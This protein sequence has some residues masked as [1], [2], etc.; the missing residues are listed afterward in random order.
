M[1]PNHTE[2]VKDIVLK[3]LHES[4]LQIE[5]MV[6]GIC[7]EVYGVALP[8]KKVI[9]RMNTDESQLRGVERNIAL[10]SS[11]NIKVPSLITSDYSKKEFP[12]GYQILSYLPGKDLG[13]VIESM[14]DNELKALAV[15]IADIFR[16]L[17]SIPTNGKFGWVGADE[18]RLVDSWAKI[19]RQDKVEE[20]NNQTGVV[21]EKLVNREKELYEKYR[22]YF[23]SVKSIL[24]YDDISSKNVLIN[25]G[26]FSGLVDLDEVTYGD[27]LA[28]IGS[29]KASWYGTHYGEVYTSAVEDVL[30]LTDDQRKMVTVYALFN[31]ILWLSERGIKFNENTNTEVDMDAVK[32]DK[33]L[34]NRL[35]LEAGEKGL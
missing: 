16:K 25:E 24:H 4:P 19:M 11:L 15:E 17:A 21:G 9:V 12:V 3:N 20:R 8:L 27:P 10:F 7:N 18:S 35:F 22:P 23:D 31:R 33:D 5:R 13:Q 28:A 2:L 29:I 34:I 1:I 32:K 30:K 26:K 6:I 14:S